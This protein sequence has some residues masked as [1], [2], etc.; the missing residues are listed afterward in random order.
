M[1]SLRDIPLLRRLAWFGGQ[2][3]V[4]DLFLLLGPLVI[5]AIAL[6]GRTGFTVG[7]AGGYILFFLGYLLYKGLSYR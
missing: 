5:V 1:E 7:L 6:I 3:T 4:F 2:N